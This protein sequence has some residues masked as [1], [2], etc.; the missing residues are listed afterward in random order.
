M[1]LSS[2]R[3]LALSTTLLAA[4][5]AGVVPATG[6]VAAPAA[7]ASA[8]ASASA[9]DAAAAAAAAPPPRPAP[10]QGG[11][12]PPQKAGKGQGAPRAQA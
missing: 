10:D 9:S 11:V 8:S 4:L 7:P 5:A 6:A 3:R 12:S 1:P 2:H